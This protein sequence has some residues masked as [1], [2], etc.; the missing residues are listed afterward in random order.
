MF[1]NRY[2]I[3]KS[4][5]VLLAMR[6][7]CMLLMAYVQVNIRVKQCDYHLNTTITA[8]SD[9]ERECN[10]PESYSVTLI[11]NYFNRGKI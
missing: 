5:K 8:I 10:V 3:Q 9:H 2:R 11:E 6:V 7:V 4:I 1:C